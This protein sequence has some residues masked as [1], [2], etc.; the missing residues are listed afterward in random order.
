MNRRSLLKRLPLGVAAAL[1]AANHPIDGAWAA[2]KI[3]LRTDFPAV[4]I[5]SALFLAQLKG[6]Y[7]DAGLDVEIQDGHGSSN[8]I[9]LLGAG[10]ID[11]AYVSLG[12]IMPARETGMKIKSFAAVTH[13]SDMGLIYDPKRG[14]GSMKDLKGK[15]LLCFS[16]SAWSPFIEPFLKTAGL[17]PK[18]VNV[19]NV[20]VNAMWSTYAVGQG[21]GVFSFPPWGLAL[22]GAKRPSKAFL[23]ADYGV[24]LLGYGLVARDETIA[25]R[26]PAL[27]KLAQVVAHSWDYIYHGH[28]EEGVEAIPKARPDVKLSPD[29]AR[30]SLELYEPYFYTPESKDQP[31]RM[32]HD[33]EWA[34]AM[35]AEESVG[36]IKGGHKTSEFYTNEV[37]KRLKPDKT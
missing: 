15:R 10:Q 21:D 5:H 19:V 24:P 23:A 2:E 3:V 29:I 22:V 6:W 37:I 33:Q 8:T 32:Q 9:Q 20:D 35:K 18:T 14:I 11:V 36:M 17:D 1:F 31:L 12:P 30:A 34:R 4:P 16:G 7:K 25:A 27:A 26:G 13:K 28:L